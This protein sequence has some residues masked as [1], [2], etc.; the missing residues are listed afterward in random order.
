MNV[1]R[2]KLVPLKDFYHGIS[3][4][5]LVSREKVCS[6]EETMQLAGI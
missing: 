6:S 2:V 5:F 4:G 1:F 3:P